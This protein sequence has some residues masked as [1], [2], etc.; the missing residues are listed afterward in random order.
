LEILS[1]VIRDFPDKVSAIKI[2]SHERNRGLAAARNTAIENCSGDFVMHVDSDDYLEK[3]AVE[4]LVNK[5][6]ETNA[7]IVS[8]CAIRE[9]KD[10]NELLREPD[11][12]NKEEMILHCIRP[13]IDHV[14]WKRLIR[15]SLYRD[16]HILSKEGVNFGEDWQVLPKLVYFADKVAKIDDIIYHYNCMNDSSYINQKIQKYDRSIALQDMQSLNIVEDFFKDKEF[17][18]QRA[19]LDFKGSFLEFHLI[20]AYQAKDAEMYNYIAKTILSLDKYCLGKI[21]WNN[22]KI[23][24]INRNYFIRRALS[25]LLS[26]I[27]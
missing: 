20:G 13:T 2:I 23:R 11:Y 17:K 14:L 8:G 6:K 24:F 26:F 1:E 7:D 10:G 4:L 18:Y 22:F 3:N 5:Q 21:G 9:A 19:I 12:S 27:H 25:S 15:L 16:Y